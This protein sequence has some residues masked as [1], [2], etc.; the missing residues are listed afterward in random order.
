MIDQDPSIATK[1]KTSKEPHRPRIEDDQSSLLKA[2]IDIAT[3]GSAADGRR[4]S[5]VY[6]TVRSLEDLTLEF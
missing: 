3:Q 2:I 6:R 5:D 1:L 4:S